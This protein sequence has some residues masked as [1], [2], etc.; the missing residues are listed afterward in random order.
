M[1]TTGSRIHRNKPTYKRRKIMK[2]IKLF[3]ESWSDDYTYDFTDK[4]FEI[5]QSSNV[6]KG[7]Y[8]G[9]FIQTELTDNFAEMIMRLSDNYYVLRTKTYFNQTTGNASF[10]VEV[11]DKFKEVSDYFL[12]NLSS[13]EQIKFY[14][15]RVNSIIRNIGINIGMVKEYL[16]MYVQGRLESGQEREIG[17]LLNEKGDKIK[18]LIRGYSGKSP[19]IDKENIT[20]LFS[21]IDSGKI[22]NNSYGDR[23]ENFKKEILGLN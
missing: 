17:I 16:I 14:P 12:I 21:I 2:N 22:P 18:A 23:Y 5:D 9:K 15:S 6:I 7:T 3:N 8:K 19:K 20:K 10:E 11:S 1:L 13:D 4:G